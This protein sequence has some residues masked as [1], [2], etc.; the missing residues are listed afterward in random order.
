MKVT[1]QE[2]SRQINREAAATGLALAAVIV[3]WLAAGFGAAQSDIVVFKLP[4]WVVTG[5]LGTWIF[6]MGLVWFLI[7]FVFR[8]MDLEDDDTE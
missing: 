2:K 3:F 7:K 1:K 6:A 4:L 8:D 5:C